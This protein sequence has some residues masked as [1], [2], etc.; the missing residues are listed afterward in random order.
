MKK[1]LLFAAIL[2]VIAGVIANIYLWQ[3]YREEPPAPE[4]FEAEQPAVVDEKL[5]L[6][7]EVE[8]PVIRY[9]VPQPP[10]PVQEEIAAEED[11]VA[12]PVE[13]P[14]PLPSLDESDEPMREALGEIFDPRK[15][16]ELFLV[17]ALVRHFVITIDNMT[18]RKL[19]QKYVFTTPPRG[20]FLI[21]RDAEENEF[22]D[23]EN[24]RRYVP[25]VRL[26]EAVNMQQ[27]VSLYTRYYPLFQEAYED[28][29]YPDRY[30]NDRF[31]EVVDHLLET[32]DVKDPVGLERPKVF[33]TFADP[34]LEALSAGQKILLRMGHDN[35]SKVK[36]R[37]RELRRLLAPGTVVPAEVAGE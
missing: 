14:E 10:P 21:T 36:A 30:F 9:P 15:F 2:V 6:P 8:K 7:G 33:Y 32:P 34:E 24:Y 13:P 26:A 4:A 20:K 16:D 29:G 5:Q 23:P 28:L 1:V 31:V 27:L 3:R 19:P 22:I 25:F 35:A 37:L 11:V 12:E 17:K 18:A